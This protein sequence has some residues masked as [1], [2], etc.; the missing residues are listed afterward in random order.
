MTALLPRP[1]EHSSTIPILAAS[2]ALPLATSNLLAGVVERLHR[3]HECCLPLAAVI[4]VVTSCL[5]DIQATPVDAL[6][7]LTERLARHRLVQIG[8]PSW[9]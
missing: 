2:Q 3:E 7:E 4:E 9:T 1:T 5:N 6:P 8:H